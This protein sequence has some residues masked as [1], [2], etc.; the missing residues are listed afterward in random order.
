MALRVLN[1]QRRKRI[2]LVIIVNLMMIFQNKEA[3]KQRNNAQEIC[4]TCR[5]I[6]EAPK[7]TLMRVSCHI[8]LLK[9]IL[10]LG[11]QVSSAVFQRFFCGP[12]T[13][14]FMVGFPVDPFS[15]FFFLFEWF[16]YQAVF[17][18]FYYYFSFSVYLFLF[19][20][21]N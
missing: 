19:L 16:F 14:C 6:I 12:A 20:L 2:H 21:L 9:F 5:K 15:S 18:F 8:Y 4:S 11:I 17:F 10:R 13:V 7:T 3:S 1:D